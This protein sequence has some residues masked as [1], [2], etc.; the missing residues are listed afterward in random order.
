[1]RCYYIDGT[2]LVAAAAMPLVTPTAIM[3]CNQYLSG[4]DRS[5]VLLG[6]ETNKYRP[7]LINGILLLPDW[8]LLCI[9]IVILCVIPIYFR[10]RIYK[11][12][13]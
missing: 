4:L 13:S 1:M 9:I 10:I 5:L 3:P 7:S 8:V 2:N 12:S 11:I 6:Y